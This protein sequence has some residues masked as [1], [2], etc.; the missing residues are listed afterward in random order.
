M[1]YS[2]PE[3]KMNFILS[4]FMY[5]QIYEKQLKVIANKNEVEKS[6]RYA[7]NLQKMSP[8]KICLSDS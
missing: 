5:K 4:V 2:H 6:F 1:K 7:R 3:V 8:Y